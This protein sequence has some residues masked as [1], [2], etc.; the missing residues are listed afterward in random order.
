M[1]NTKNKSNLVK[2]IFA[3]LQQCCG[4]GVGDPLPRHNDVTAFSTFSEE[5]LRDRTTTPKRVHFI[6]T[7]KSYNL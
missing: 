5:I 4:V 7:I 6:I 1:L 3:N 2:D